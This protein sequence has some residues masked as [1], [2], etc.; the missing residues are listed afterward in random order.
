[1]SPRLLQIVSIFFIGYGI[2]DILFV[3][4]ILGIALLIIGIAMM[5][6]GIKKQR[7]LKQPKK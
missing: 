5:A 7:A 1:M 6:S 4:Y 2:I 3:N